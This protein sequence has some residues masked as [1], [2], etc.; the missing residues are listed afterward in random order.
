MDRI[1]V[2]L[3]CITTLCI[4]WIINKKEDI[5]D[6][7]SYLEKIE[8][9]EKKVDSLHT[10]NTLLDLQADTLQIRIVEYDK[11]ISDLTR[12]ITVIKKE[13]N[14]KLN[15]VNILNDAELE[16]F[17]AELYRQYKDSIN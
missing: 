9:L 2:I 8:L 3:L 4:F 10:K 15:S 17:F 5:V 6:V 16:R 7:S 14:E 12:S 1:T 11:K 13:T